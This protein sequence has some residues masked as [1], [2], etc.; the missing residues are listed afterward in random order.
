M[1]LEEFAK[2]Y[3]RRNLDNLIKRL[4]I[5]YRENL[6]PYKDM[7]EQY[8]SF[9]KSLQFFNR[10]NNEIVSNELFMMVGNYSYYKS[11]KFLHKVESCLQN[12]RYN[13]IQSASILDF[14]CN[15]RWSSGYGAQFAIRA[16]NLATAITWY[17]NCFDYILQ[18]IYLAFDLY[19]KI[20]NYSSS[21]T[22]EEVLKKYTYS[23][24]KEIFTNNSAIPNFSILWNIIENCHTA[25]SDVNEW[26]NFIKHKGGINILGLSPNSPARALVTDS[27]GNIIAENSEFSPIQ[28][29]LDTALI[30]LQGAHQALYTCLDQIVTFIDYSAA[31]PTTTNGIMQ[32]TPPASYVKIIIP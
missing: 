7:I 21:W 29:D 16:I 32:I 19:K 1:S 11:A 15:V 8:R 9:C 22:I 14:N 26:A 27:C 13:L 25:L 3:K 24:I 2:K 18:I 10:Y 28:I 17:N 4:T 31:I 20:P 12:A 30:T 6:I 23:K 5:E